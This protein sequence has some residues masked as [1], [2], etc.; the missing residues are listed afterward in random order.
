MRNYSSNSLKHIQCKMSN[1]S[2]NS[3]K[4]DKEIQKTIK[5]LRTLTNS[6]R[7]AKPSWIILLGPLQP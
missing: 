3:L 4:Q 2:S 1:Y 6:K 5:K 7:K